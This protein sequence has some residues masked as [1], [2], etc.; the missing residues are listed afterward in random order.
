[1][2]AIAR[3]NIPS[4]FVYGGSIMP[5]QFQDRDVNIQDV[6]EAVGAYSKGSISAEDLYELEC[7]A[8]PGEGS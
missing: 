5:G 6:F 3:L 2:M 4:I 7:N 8:C 1:M